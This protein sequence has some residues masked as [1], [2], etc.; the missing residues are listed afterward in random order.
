MY[1]QAKFYA[2]VGEITRIIIEAIT[3]RENIALSSSEISR[4]MSR[5]ILE[6]G[7]NFFTNFHVKV[8]ENK[9]RN[10]RILFALTLQV[11]DKDVNVKG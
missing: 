7:P 1:C 6:I 9:E 2:L 10:S 8:R 5:N 3:V 4:E 11:V